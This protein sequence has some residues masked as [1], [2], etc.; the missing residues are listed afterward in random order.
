MLPI[1][2]N[3]APERTYREVEDTE[4]V[5][6]QYPIASWAVGSQ[7]FVFPVTAIQEDGGNRVVVRKRAYRDG[8]KLDDTGSNEKR[9]VLTAVFSASIIEPGLEENGDL[10]LYP[11]VLNALIDSFDTHETGDLVVPTRGPVRARIERYSRIEKVDEEDYAG[12]S[13]TFIEDNEDNV[14]ARSFSQSSVNANAR[15]LADETTFSAQSDGA[16]DGS[17]QDLNELAA[18]LEGLANAPGDI[19]RDLDQQAGMVIGAANRATRAFSRSG[20]EGRDLFLDP[21]SSTT[22]RKLE[23]TKEIAGRTRIES[24]KGRPALVTVVFEEDQSLLNIAAMLNQNFA[25]L[26]EVN[27]QLE[28]PLHVPAGEIVRVF[29]NGASA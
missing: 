9:W 27:S 1:G 16:W 23:Q 10:P 8:A 15:L 29:G 19:L 11:D 4:S 22:Q 13:L 2:T 6:S 21:D 17:L 7:K 26:L 3:N 5:F 18:Q 25:D 24:R 12:L 28:N 14:D 20:V